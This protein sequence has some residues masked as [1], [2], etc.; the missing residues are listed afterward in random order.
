LLRQRASRKE[1][2][3]SSDYIYEAVRKFLHKAL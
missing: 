1:D 2:C 3:G